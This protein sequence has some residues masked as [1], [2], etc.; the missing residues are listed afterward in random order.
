[1]VV[2]L[3]RLIYYVSRGPSGRMTLAV[4]CLMLR[5]RDHG[6]NLALIKYR[7]RP[8]GWARGKLTGEGIMSI[9]GLER[10]ADTWTWSGY[11]NNSLQTEMR[12]YRNPKD[13]LTISDLWAATG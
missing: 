1:M 10:Y 6:A 8:K 9:S 3:T 12:R 7:E 4:G 5:L 13:R 11:P 2:W